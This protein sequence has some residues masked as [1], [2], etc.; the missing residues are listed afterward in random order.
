[1]KKQS[2]LLVGPWIGEFGWELFCW[3]G[4]IRKLSQE[5]DRT[6]VIGRINNKI[7]YEDFCDE[8]IE[9][10]PDGW[11]T[12]GWR[13]LNCENKEN[14]KDKIPHDTY[15]SGKFD[16][17]YLSENKTNFFTQQLFYR[18]TS[19]ILKT[20]YDIIF[21][22]R[23]KKT[24]NDRNWD[25]SQWRQLYTLLPKTLKIACIGN[26]E[27]FVIDGTDDLRDIKLD[28]LVSIMNNS[29]LIVGPSSGPMHLASL[30][31]LKHLVWSDNSNF[32]RYINHWNPF[33]TE[34][35]FYNQENWNPN[36][37]SIYSLIENYT[38]LIFGYSKH[39]YTNKNDTIVKNYDNITYE[40]N[41]QFSHSLNKFYTQ[42]EELKLLDKRY[43]IYGTGTIGKIIYSLMEKQI[44]ACVDISDKDNH[45]SNLNNLSFDNII[46]SVFGREIGI[47]K[48]LTEELKI[49]K[50]KI[51]TFN[52]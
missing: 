51:I 33:Y 26:K 32:E 41:Y 48:Y 22:C 50:D 31:G 16:I 21:H 18:Y 52:M 9:F 40:N 47:I 35:I 43:I 6:I 14:Y 7:L 45:P 27:A 24:G 5:Y 2:T 39:K 37:Q 29:K 28:A 1:M 17:G 13:C 11:D 3:Q 10:D 30:C 4:Y 44:V 36:P 23:N 38:D 20:G 25:I 12:D 46:I 34:V 8:Y 49:D 19:S 15:I 42:V